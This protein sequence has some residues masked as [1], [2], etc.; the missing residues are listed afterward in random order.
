MMPL[1]MPLHTIDRDAITIDNTRFE[2]QNASRL[3][4]SQDTKQII[5]IVRVSLAKDLKDT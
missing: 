5:L 1:E 2:P 3:T 4:K